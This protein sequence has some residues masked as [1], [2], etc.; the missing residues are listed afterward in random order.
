MFLLGVVLTVVGAALV[1]ADLI[2]VFAFTLSKNLRIT[3]FNYGV[4]VTK[5]LILGAGIA[6]LLLA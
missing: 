2:M 4:I 6:L 1:L 3:N 5:L